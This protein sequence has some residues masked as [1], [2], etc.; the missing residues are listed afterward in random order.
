MACSG[1]HCAGCAGGMA[2][3]LVPLAAAYGLAWIAENIIMVA[4]V[5][6]ACGAL[7]VAAVVA[8]MR[9]ADRRDARRA[10]AGPLMV[11]RAA[12]AVFPPAGA[13]AEIGPVYHFN[14]F[15]PAGDA[16]A[17]VIRQAI[18]GTAGD[19]PERNGK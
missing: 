7:A 2:V 9:Q 8:L 14:F 12:P 6:A 10:A 18:T 1:L 13:R 19:A 17:A 11:T 16:Q 15:T 5:S 3:P 4:S